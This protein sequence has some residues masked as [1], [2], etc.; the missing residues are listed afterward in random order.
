VSKDVHNLKEVMKLGFV[1]SAV[2]IKQLKDG[3]QIT[4]IPAFLASEELRAAV[5]PAVEGITEIPGEIAD[6]SL[7][8]GMELGIFAVNEVRK[9]I[10]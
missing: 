3:F 8:E 10:L 2:L 4:D 7:V 1:V 5:A 9:L 6:I